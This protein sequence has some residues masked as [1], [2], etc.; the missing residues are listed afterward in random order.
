MERLTVGLIQLS[1][2]RSDSGR[3]AR[4]ALEAATMA[5]RSGCDVL[6]MP[7]LWNAAMPLTDHRSLIAENSP[8]L[9][10]LGSLAGRYG[11]WIIAGSLAVK[12]AEGPRNRSYVFSPEGERFF[13][14]DKLHLY[15]GLNEPNMLEPGQSLGLFKMESA[16]AG[17]MICF[18]M[19]FPEIARAL[20]NR[21]A[22]MLL[23]PG[24]WKTE[25]IRL[26][27]HLLVSRAI[28]N[29][30]FLIGV[31][32]C[33]RGGAV[34]FGGSSMVV[35]PFGDVALELD[36]RPRFEKISLDLTRVEKARKEHRVVASLRPDI[37]RKWQ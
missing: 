8:I 37:Y 19:E 9:E 27:R 12:S 11:L 5:A 33:D 25:Y 36:D 23:V 20:A 1:V 26:W 2:I 4:A 28:E 34:R 30:V 32:R 16:A 35:D 15:P 13:R 3:N 10:T 18:D 24:A 31:N 17:V 6:L 29:Q 14:Y 22:R 21:G 7:E